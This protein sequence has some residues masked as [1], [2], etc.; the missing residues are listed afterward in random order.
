MEVPDWLGQ[1]AGTMH[2]PYVKERYPSTHVPPFLHGLGEQ[3]C[4][5]H[6]NVMSVQQQVTVGM[7]EGGG[8]FHQ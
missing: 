4:V 5:G 7:Q 8:S 2:G 1:Q 6:M 3:S